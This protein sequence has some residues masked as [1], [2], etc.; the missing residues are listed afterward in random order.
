MTQDT[1]D[2]NEAGLQVRPEV[3]GLKGRRHV[4]EAITEG[5]V[6]SRALYDP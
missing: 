1:V 3:G 4:E 6:I 2:L 5:Q